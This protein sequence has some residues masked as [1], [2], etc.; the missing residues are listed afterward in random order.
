MVT[1]DRPGTGG[2]FEEGYFT[3]GVGKPGFGGITP[4]IAGASASTGNI[5]QIKENVKDVKKDLLLGWQ[6]FMKSLGYSKDQAGIPT[7]WHNTK[8]NPILSMFKNIK[9]PKLKEQGKNLYYNYLRADGVIPGKFEYSSTL[10]NYKAPISTTTVSN[11]KAN[12]YKK[13]DLKTKKVSSGKNTQTVVNP[14]VILGDKATL[15]ERLFY[16]P[17]VRK[18]FIDKTGSV[19]HRTHPNKGPNRTLEV[20]KNPRLKEKLDQPSGLNTQ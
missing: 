9:N 20:V 10:K 11:P 14:N 12:P 15:N 16:N 5:K 1:R 3:E 7:Y 13:F 17:K 2:I 4:K 8:G 6:S 19:L 18:Y